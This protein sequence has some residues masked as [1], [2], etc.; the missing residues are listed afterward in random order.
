MKLDH[1]AAPIRTHRQIADEL[2]RRGVADLTARNVEWILRQAL[3]KLRE[4]LREY[5]PKGE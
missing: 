1:P 2:R 5:E 4:Q 3:R